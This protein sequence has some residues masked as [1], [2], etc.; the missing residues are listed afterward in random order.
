MKNAVK[1]SERLNAKVARNENRALSGTR[2]DYVLEDV[3][4]PSHC[5]ILPLFLAAKIPALEE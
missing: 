2:L 4:S 3:S 5:K 1:S